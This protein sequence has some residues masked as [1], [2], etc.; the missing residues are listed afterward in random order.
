[1]QA[2]APTV[3]GLARAR[4]R[5]RFGGVTSARPPLGEHA[6]VAQG[7]RFRLNVGLG[8]TRLWL[9]HLGESCG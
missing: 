5:R 3:D 4:D 2:L 1:M 6:P 7:R 9:A 8:T